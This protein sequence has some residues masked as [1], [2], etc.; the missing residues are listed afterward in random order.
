MC[1]FI[2]VLLLLLYFYYFIIF[3]HFIFYYISIII[4][5]LLAFVFTALTVSNLPLKCAGK[6]I[7]VNRISLCNNNRSYVRP[8]C[9]FAIAPCIHCC[10]KV[11]C[12]APCHLFAYSFIIR[13]FL[14]VEI[15]FYRV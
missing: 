9:V 2:I 14:V 13:L 7:C 4:V 12:M 10:K 8:W 1:C 11:V 5:V 6:N 15:L 3:L